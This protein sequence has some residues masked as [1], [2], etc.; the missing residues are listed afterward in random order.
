MASSS[1]KLVSLSPSVAANRQPR[2]K[3]ST[4]LGIQRA[5]TIQVNSEM[6]CQQRLP[7]QSIATSRREVMLRLTVASLAAINIFSVEPVDARNVK[8]GIRQKIKEKLEM[9]REKAGI[10]NSQSDDKS[11]SDKVHRWFHAPEQRDRLS[12]PLAMLSVTTKAPVGSP[13]CP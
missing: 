6:C 11:S 8:P 10:T 9:L 3:R 7:P 2:S 13:E 1:A 12:A 5:P 4:V